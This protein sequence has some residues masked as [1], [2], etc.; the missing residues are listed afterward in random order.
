MINASLKN[1]HYFSITFGQ[2]MYICFINNQPQ[3]FRPSPFASA[4]YIFDFLQPSTVFPLVVQLSSR[5]WLFATPRTAAH[6]AFLSPTS[7]WSLPNF[8]SIELVMPSNHLILCHPLLLLPSMF[9]SI[10]GFSNES[11]VC[12]RWPK[13]WSFSFSKLS[14]LLW[15]KKGGPET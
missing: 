9:H 15:H 13:Y 8:V 11:A 4:Y 7:S 6:Q 1:V 2:I 14:H 5:V 10:R 3:F 12:I